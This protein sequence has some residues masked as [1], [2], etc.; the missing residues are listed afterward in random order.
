MNSYQYAAYGS[1][2]HPDR[3]RRRVPSAT[4]RG[5]GFVSGLELRFHKAGRLDGSG[6]CNILP[7]EN[8]VYVAVFDI[9]ESERGILDSCEGLG[10]G[11]N[12]QLIDVDRFGSCSTYIGDTSA[13]DNSL[14]PFDWYREYV[15]RGAKLHG[16][17]TEYLTALENVL[18][19][20]DKDRN[21]SE[22][23]WNLI[24]SLSV[25]N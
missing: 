1:N 4:L 14:R 21:R 5:V 15:V 13:I 11:Y 12:H 20:V 16:F 6:K 10:A 23:E 8:G 19:D 25:G 24:K 17:P 2:L 18:A 3:L 22:R 9:D 7:G